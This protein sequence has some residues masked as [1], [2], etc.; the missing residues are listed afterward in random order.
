[1]P[2]SALIARLAF[3]D[4]LA[5]LL[6]ASLVARQA[7]VALLSRSNRSNSRDCRRCQERREIQGEQ[8]ASHRNS[9]APRLRL[10]SVTPNP[11][12]AGAGSDTIGS[13]AISVPSLLLDGSPPRA[14]KSKAQLV[15]GPPKP[16]V[17]R[18]LL[19]LLFASDYYDG[20]C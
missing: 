17:Y 19:V 8:P 14:Q 12:P 18:L 6:G 20:H 11:L 16:W 5:L 10:G 1:M 9:C 3:V 7:F 2:R 15:A 13:F 4:L